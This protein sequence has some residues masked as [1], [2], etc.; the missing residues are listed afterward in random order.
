[1]WIVG[2]EVFRPGVAVCKIAPS[3]AG[4]ANLF[5]ELARM[6]QQ[7][8]CTPALARLDS[9]HHTCSARSY[10]HDLSV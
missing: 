6:I 1:M 2:N 8:Y 10:H 9:A 4:Y 5:G 3:A 7:Q